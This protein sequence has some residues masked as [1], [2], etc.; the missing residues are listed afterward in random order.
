LLG[1]Q[2]RRAPD[3]DQEADP[4][5]PVRPHG[6]EFTGLALGGFSS[7]VLNDGE[8]VAEHHCRTECEGHL[9]DEEIEIDELFHCRDASDSIG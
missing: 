9:L 8:G 7:L 5:E 1:Q 6:A 3:S 4:E 2:T